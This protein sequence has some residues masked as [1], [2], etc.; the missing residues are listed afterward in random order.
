MKNLLLA[1]MIALPSMMA[2]NAPSQAAPSSGTLVQNVD[3]RP[4][5]KHHHRRP[6]RDCVVRTE[7]QRVNGRI[8]LRK[9]RVCR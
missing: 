2:F 7:K 3:Y 1:T 8:V 5:Y 9:V 6:N 4:G